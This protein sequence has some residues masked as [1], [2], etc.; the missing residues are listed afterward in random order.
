MVSNK[1]EQHPAPSSHQEQEEDPSGDGG[2]NLTASQINNVGVEWFHAGELTT[3]FQFFYHAIERF[4]AGRA[5]AAPPPPAVPSSSSSQ[6]RG[7]GE[8]MMMGQ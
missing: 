7:S 1:Q 2:V 8:A 6:H 4:K 5:A 3:A